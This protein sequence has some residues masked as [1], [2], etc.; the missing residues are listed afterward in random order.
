[1]TA[2]GCVLGGNSFA[3]EFGFA[4]RAA[5]ICAPSVTWKIGLGG[6]EKKRPP[7]HIDGANVPVRRGGLFGGRG[8]DAKEAALT[9]MLRMAR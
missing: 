7:S 8:G 5:R 4:R 3:A 9:Q 6:P 2:F 1:M